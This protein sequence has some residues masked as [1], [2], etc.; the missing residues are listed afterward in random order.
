MLTVTGGTRWFDFHNF[1]KGSVVSGFGCSVSYTGA[2][3][4][5]A[6]ATNLDAKHLQSAAYGFRS[7]A[8]ITWKITPDIMVYY[9]WSQ[10][11]RPAGFNRR[12]PKSGDFVGDIAYQSD[13]LTNNEVGYKMQFFQ[14]RLT[15]NGAFYQED[16]NNVQDRLFDPGAFGNLAFTVNGPNYRVRGA[17]VQVVALPI[18]GL[19]LA[20]SFAAN[21]TRQLTSPGFTSATGQVLPGSVGIFGNVGD[22]LAQSPA[23]KGDFR[24]RYEFSVLDDY[25]CFVQASV[26]H[27]SHMHSAVA[28]FNNF[29]EAPITTV[30]AAVGV[31]KDSWRAQVYVDNLTDERGQEFISAAQFVQSIIVTRPLTAGL[32]VSYSFN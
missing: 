24:A 25:L 27:S 3:P 16:W 14:H 2:V 6:G 28:T 8:N 29:Y 32:K 30:N 9:T 26:S 23:F 19:N 7:R 4:C 21:D 10:G 20:G 31:S 12:A 18:D 5:T 17:E 1:E 22:T 11:Y 13:S 15:V